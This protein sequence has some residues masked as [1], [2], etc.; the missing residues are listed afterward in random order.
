MQTLQSVCIFIKTQIKKKVSK[1]ETK[2]KERMQQAN[3]LL[4]KAIL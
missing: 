4:A 3:P 1:T 2:K